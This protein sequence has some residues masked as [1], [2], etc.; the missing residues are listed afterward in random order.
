MST[1]VE[2]EKNST[3]SEI[4]SFIVR[5]IKY[6]WGGGT[7]CPGMWKIQKCHVSKKNIFLED[8]QAYFVGVGEKY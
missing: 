6:G 3:S 7:L 4:S 2:N 5:A 1:R 8:K